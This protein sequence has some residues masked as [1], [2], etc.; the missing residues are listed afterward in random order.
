MSKITIQ[1][2]TAR[3][4]EKIN[5]YINV[6][7]TNIKLPVTLICGKSEGD[8]VLI[9]AGV[10]CAEYVG[11]ETA[12]ELSREINPK[13]I[14]GNIII[15]PLINR[16]GFEHR[17][18]SI[19][20]EDGKNLNRVIPGHAE[21]SVSERIAYF[22]EKELFSKVD[23][24]IDLHCGDGYEELTPYVY[25]QGIAN[26]EV[27]S[28]S[29]QMAMAINSEYIVVSQSGSGGAY[30]YAGSIGLPGILIERGCMG[31]WSSEEVEEYKIDVRNVLKELKVLS[32]EKVNRNNNTKVITNTIYEDSV[33]TG[34]WYA[35]YKVGDIV[36]RGDEL[37]T[38]RDYF[39]NILHSCIA[40]VD[41]VV[42]YQVGSL[43]VLKDGPMITYGEI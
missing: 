24:Y 25:C 40:K 28:K 7:N 35:N 38:V 34:C 37:G 42:L 11:I 14:S 20:Y 21:G 5:G 6:A 9:T 10:H 8:T 30:N 15:I 18:M 29:R 39:G 36:S 4:G 1:N 32:G 33:Y 41:G 3:Q 23:Y 27:L 12:I 19:V 13:N 2:L 22:M 43:S 26:E 31:K 16:S 17:T